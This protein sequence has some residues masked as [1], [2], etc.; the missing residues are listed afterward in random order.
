MD[1]LNFN[2]QDQ[3][4]KN[5]KPVFTII[6]RGEKKYYVRIGIAF[7]NHDHSLNVKLDGYPTNG[8]LHIRDWKPWELERMA[9]SAAA[10]ALE[11]GAS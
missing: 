10:R 11:G 5:R 6:D 1:E 9:Q 3:P 8:S 2:G 7:V 4:H